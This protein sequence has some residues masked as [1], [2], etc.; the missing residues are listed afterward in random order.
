M[1]IWT[2]TYPDVNNGLGCRVTLWLAGCSHHCEGCQN[3][4]TWDFK[5]GREF[6]EEDKSKLF[7][8]LSKPYIKGLTLSGGD[9]LDSFD[10]VLNLVKE[11]KERFPSK[12]VWLY[13]GYTLE[14][15][16]N[17]N[18]KE[19][20]PYVNYLVDGEFHIK[21]RDIT[22]KFKGS[23]NQIIWEK[24]NEGNFIKSELN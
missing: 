11:M 12:D 22:L 9:P 20:L 19:I 1:R 13:T 10:G 6:T 16:Q 15:I 14:E 18:K 7:E 23:K 17:C 24:D 2:I 5:S 8:I 21:E 4:K 3:K